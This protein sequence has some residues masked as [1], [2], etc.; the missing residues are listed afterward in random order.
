MK[1]EQLFKVFGTGHAAV[2]DVS[3]HVAAGEI[4][5]LLG[6][7]AAARPRRCAA[8][9]AWSTRRRARSRSAMHV[10]SAPAAAR[11]CRRACATSAWCSSRTR[12]G[13]T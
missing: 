5:V 9:P 2:N 11:W 1:V 8:S 10:V 13:R 3:F 12:C 4:V 7:S 6:P